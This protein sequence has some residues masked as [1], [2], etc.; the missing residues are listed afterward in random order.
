[1]SGLKQA[2]VI[3][4]DLE[5]SKGKAIAQACHA[6]LGAYKKASKSER[7]EWESKGS[8]K[9]VLYSGDSALEDLLMQTKRNKIPAYL[10]KDAGRTELEP[11][12]KTALGIGPSEESKIDSITGQLRLVE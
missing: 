6:S 8:K 10:V 12:T 3:R 4:E 5:I 9:V 11:G 7:S 1:M 2:I